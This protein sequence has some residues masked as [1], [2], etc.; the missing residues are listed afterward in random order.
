MTK[1]ED[2]MSR[3]DLLEE[4]A[5]RAGAC[6]QTWLNKAAEMRREAQELTVRDSITQ[7]FN[8]PMTNFSEDVIKQ[9]PDLPELV[10]SGEFAIITGEA[11]RVVVKHGG[12]TTTEMFTSKIDARQFLENDI[13]DDIDSSDIQPCGFFVKAVRQVKGEL[14]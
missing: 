10:K 2:L 14:F 1:Y 7:Y 8:T 3:A 6:K 9:N 4:T 11:W 5:K 13:Q 12:D